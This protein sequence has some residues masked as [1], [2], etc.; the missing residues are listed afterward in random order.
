VTTGLPEPRVD[1]AEADARLVAALRAGD[2]AAFE[3]LVR[4]H[5]AGLLHLAMF[6]VG[7]RAVAEEVV[8]ETWLGVLKGL[9]R[10]EQ[11]SSVKTW[12]YRILSNIAKTRAVSEKRSR[13]F[14]SYET[15]ADE[16]SG[17]VVD[18]DRFLPADHDR[19][20]G[21]WLQPPT[22]WADIPEQRL[23]SRETLRQLAA[24]LDALPARQQAVF[25]LRDVEGWSA[26]DTC[27]ALGITEVNQRVL[28]H[29]ARGRLRTALEDYVHGGAG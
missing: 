20:P 4:Q 3:S 5:S 9:D 15:V 22:S 24:A 28:L 25:R 8:Q 29:R 19:W 1:T 11:R 26:G 21:F 16:D 13:P 6:H 10:F 17:P 2:E 7:S 23:M 18:P 12:I 14:S 27:D